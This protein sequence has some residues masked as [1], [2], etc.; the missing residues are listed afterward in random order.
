M[1]VA[2]RSSAGGSGGDGEPPTDLLQAQQDHGDVVAPARAVGLGDQRVAG[3]AQARVGAQQL[4]DAGLG[5]HR[6]E[7]VAAQQVHVGGV[8]AEGA[9]VDLDGLLGSERAGD[10]RALRVLFGFG[11]REAALADQLVDERVVVGQ[12]QQLP[13]AQAV[14]AAVPDVGDRDLLLADVDGGER[15]AH[16]GLLGVA[17]GE[18]VDAGVGGARVQGQSVLGGHGVGEAVVEGLHGD[19]RGDLA[20]LRPAHAVGD[21]EQRRALQQRVLVG[22]PLAAGVGGGVVLCD[23]QHLNRPRT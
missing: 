9:R 22:A 16:A 19:P 14:R 1:R 4:G 20:G 21:D 7:P 13:I 6:G 8:R 2:W 18:L 15:G 3:G 5:D 10:D 17:L 12:A 11:G 23:A